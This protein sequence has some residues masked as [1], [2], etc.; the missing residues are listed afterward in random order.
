MSVGQVSP[1]D[2][3]L[4]VLDDEESAF[5]KSHIGIADDEELKKHILAVQEKAYKVYPYPCIRRFAF[6]KLKISRLPAYPHFL[7]LGKTRDPAIFLDI[8]CCFGNDARKAVAD[9]YPIRNVIASDLR[10][11]YWELGHE[12]FRSTP[13]SLPVPF[14][15]GDA[16]DSEFLTPTQPT[17]SP[18]TTP[19]P[20]LQSV[21]ALTPLIGHVSAVHASAF[22]HLFDEAGQFE[23]A[24][25]MAS[26][27]SPQP[28]SII[29][30]SHRG[31]PQKGMRTNARG[32]QSFAHSPESWDELWNGSIFEKGRV[33]VDARVVQV[34]RPDLNRPTG[35]G[36][37]LLEWS[38]TRL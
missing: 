34:D 9:G 23:L 15:A 18:P 35:G 27:L 30:G 17:Y 29:F 22:F 38:V 1:L 10:P 16:F 20:D 7:E 3:T 28:G 6:A 12:L 5:F 13:Q 24:Q 8:G 4:Y 11:E 26:L 19:V 31:L 2:P 14:V 33:R 32:Q 25:R 37:Y 21:T 36:H